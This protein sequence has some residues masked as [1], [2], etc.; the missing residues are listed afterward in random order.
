MKAEKIKFTLE[1]VK[2]NSRWKVTTDLPNSKS[3][4]KYFSSENEVGR[5]I[6]GWIDITI[7]NE[8][9][10]QAGTKWWFYDVEE[11]R[12]IRVVVKEIINKVDTLSKMFYSTLV[13]ENGISID[14]YFLSNKGRYSIT[15]KKEL[16]E[17]LD[18]ILKKEYTEF[19][20]E[21]NQR[22]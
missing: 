22:I 14:T 18:R 7:S 1:K 8:S 9:P 5:Y 11:E 21:D 3:E 17:A 20:Y 16:P 4:V 13:F 2:S 15:D 6:K 12:I 10:Y 19:L